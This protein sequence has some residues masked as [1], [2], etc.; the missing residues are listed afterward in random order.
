M[1]SDRR[2]FQRLKLAKPL[3]ALLDGHNALILDIGVAGAFI[4][5]YGRLQPGARV[6]LTFRWQANDVEFGCSV[7]RSNVVRDDAKVMSQTALQFVESVGD[8]TTRLK[9]MM[10]TFVGQILVALK[11]NAWARRETE[12]DT[13]LEKI[14]GARR[15]R[16]TGRVMYRLNGKTWTR[17]RTDS[18]VQP[19]DGF[20]VAA[21]EDEEELEIL[22]RAYEAADEA[23][24]QMI[25]VIAELSARSIK[26]K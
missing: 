20:T 21:Y 11:D 2:D 19:A 14:G 24:R 12:S 9:Q 22:C 8:A 7:V 3:M 4:E 10:A 25:R 13:I 16:S 6:R 5:H 17:T 23:G 15:G 18:A 1:A 26:T